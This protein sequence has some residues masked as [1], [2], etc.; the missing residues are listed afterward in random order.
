MRSSYRSFVAGV[1]AGLAMLGAACAA[2]TVPP[3]TTTL[4]HPEFLYPAVPA[5]MQRT[6]AAQH[7]D[8]G[9]RYLQI[10][11]L[12]SA[13]R[14]FAAALK[15]EPRMF[16]A[17]TGHG[18]VALARRDFDRAVRAFNTALG[19][20]QS[21]A[22]AL[23][24]RGQ[25]LL[26]LR[27]EGEALASFEAALKADPS[28]SDVRQRA[29]LL[30]FRGVQDLIESARSFAKSGQIPDARAAYEQAIAASP[31]S[32][33]LY[34]ELGA[35]ERRAGNVDEALA[36]MRRATELDPLDATAFV[37]LAELHES[38]Q[39]FAGAEAAYRKAVELDPS[40]DLETR[41]AAAA[42][43]AREAALPPEFKVAL[44]APQITRGDL[45]ALIGVR[46]EPIVRAAPVRQVVLTDT[47]GHWAA[48]WIAQVAGAGIIPPFENHTFQPNASVR[49]GDLAVAVSRLLA[50]IA[51]G[52]P[53]LRARAAQ[54][55]AIADMNRRHVQYAAAASAVATGVMPLLEGERFQV[56]R[57]VSGSEAVDVLDRVRALSAQSANAG[58]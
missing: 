16:P 22:P 19:I 36:Q 10:D 53:A 39:D 50:L 32:A 2:R 47:R 20:Q 26:A 41:L 45:A 57:L 5:A 4:A 56:G 40:P 7:V 18:Y 48:S 24:G 43:N 35:L 1:L 11:D 6:F 49:R 30:R 17:H 27:R 13:D 54:R 44:S 25:A 31:E 58:L 9:W 37:Q 42:K 23:V 3:P 34:R 46:L 21:Y 38:R 33:F 28:L 8:I 14:E 15:G 51:A 12:R 55:P 52:D 29:E